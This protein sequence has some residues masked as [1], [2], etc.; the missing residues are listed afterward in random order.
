MTDEVK[1]APE[2]QNDPH[3]ARAAVHFNVPY[4]EVTDEQRAAGKALNFAQ[5]YTLPKP[6]EVKDLSGLGDVVAENE[7]SEELNEGQLAAKRHE[8][9]EKQWGDIVRGI[10]RKS[11]NLKADAEVEMPEGET[12]RYI[13]Y[14]YDNQ[15]RFSLGKAKGRRL[16]PHQSPAAIELLRVTNFCLHQ[17]LGKVFKAMETAAKAEGEDAKPSNIDQIA[18]DKCR[19]K[20]FAR[21][22]DVIHRS[23]ADAKKARRQ[24]HRTARRINFGLIPGNARRDSHSA[25]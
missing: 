21:A 12:G 11:K 15:G 23:K 13:K 9:A 1:L 5:M 22:V 3:R 16:R 6:G 2:G 19:D 18:F 10:I 8:L 25:A 20:A 14:A 24:R 7:K 4:D 17:E